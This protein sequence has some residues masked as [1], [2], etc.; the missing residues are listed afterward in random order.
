MFFLASCAAST[1]DEG[2][3]ESIMQLNHG[4]DFRGNAMGDGVHQVLTR[5]ASN[6]IYNMPDEITC[7]IPMDIADSTFYEVDYNFDEGE[8]NHIRLN[9]YPQTDEDLERLKLEFT[10]FYDHIYQ[11]DE[12][13]SNGN[14]TTRSS[15]GKD[16]HIRM[17][18]N[19]SGL[20]QPSLSFTFREED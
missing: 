7:R 11:K 16:V 19:P 15:R 4:G 18:L 3:V 14:W 5:E 8:L 6:I 20:P 13:A 2:E 9:L 1:P 12:K 10:S 17:M